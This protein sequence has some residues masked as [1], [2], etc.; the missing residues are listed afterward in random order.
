MASIKDAKHGEEEFSKDQ[1]RAFYLVRKALVFLYFVLVPF[2]QS[3]S[4]CLNYFHQKGERNFG[5]FDC[6][7]VSAETGYRYSAF[8]TFSPLLTIL[9]D[10]VCMVCFCI[11]ICHENGWRN[12]SKGEKR[13]TAIMVIACSISLI[14]LTRAFFAMK[15]PYFANLMRIPILLSFS[16]RLRMNTVSLFH[17]LKDSFAILLTIFTY[18]LLFVITV[19]YFYRPMFQGIVNFTT[20][21]SSYLAMTVLFTTANFPDIFLPAMN[22]NYFNA[23]LFMFFM[24]VGL[25]FLTNLLTANVFNKYMNRLRA[26]REKR[27]KQRMDYIETIFKKHDKDNS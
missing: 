5:L 22:I 9:I 14:D 8:P 10:L 2:C 17:D 25:Y 13:R 18:I 15:F 27:Q 12:Q 19:Y 24:L 16:H 4:W 20:M 26:R 6:D 7:M 3:P 21:K 1:R 23:F 11:M